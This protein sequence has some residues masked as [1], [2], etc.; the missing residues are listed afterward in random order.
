MRE[1]YP[2]DS[3]AQS[4]KPIIEWVQ[5]QLWMITILTPPASFL[6]GKSSSGAST[7]QRVHALYQRPFFQTWPQLR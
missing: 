6:V 3:I 7:S 5:S 1:I 4:N 2:L